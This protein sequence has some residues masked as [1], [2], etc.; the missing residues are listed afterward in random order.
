MA[1]KCRGH[2]PG[3]FL[4][5]WATRLSVAKMTEERKRQRQSSEALKSSASSGLGQSGEL[6]AEAAGTGDWQ[7]GKRFSSDA[8]DDEVDKDRNEALE[9]GSALKREGGDRG[10]R[11]QQH[12]L[13]PS[14]TRRPKLHARVSI[15]PRSYSA[16]RGICEHAKRRYS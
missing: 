3:T 15:F 12:L 6:L 10:G 7:D 13:A 8:S 5:E 4:S 11:A 9:P 2:F 16:S 14:F 1:F